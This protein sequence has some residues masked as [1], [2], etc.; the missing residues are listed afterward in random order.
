MTLLCCCTLSPLSPS[1]SLYWILSCPSPGEVKGVPPIVL[2]NL[3]GAISG[4]SV[5]VFLLFWQERLPLIDRITGAENIVW[6]CPW[7]AF[8]VVFWLYL[9]HWFLQG[10]TLSPWRK[11]NGLHLLLT[12]RHLLGSWS[13]LGN[14]SR[15]VPAL[16]SRSQVQILPS[17]NEKSDQIG[18]LW[19]PFC[20][21]GLSV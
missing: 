20:L 11:K 8:K 4:E 12:S 3:V 14:N 17:R 2:L 13:E 21:E 5:E 19:R 18:G 6:K 1:Y 15:P 9:R 16:Q 10:D 7:K